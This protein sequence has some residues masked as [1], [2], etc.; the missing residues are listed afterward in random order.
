[1]RNLKLNA[2][3]KLSLIIAFIIGASY[4][5]FSQ[6]NFE[7]KSS[8]FLIL[9]ETTGDGVKLTSQEGCAWKELTFTLNPDQPQAI[10]QYGMTSLNKSKPTEDKNLASFLFIIKRTKEGISLSGKGGT[11]WTK[12]SFDCTKGK[13]SQYVDFNGMAQKH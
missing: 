3:L 11:A 2:F 10:D 7:T 4:A 12:L 8:K 13:C 6:V 9:V 1:M 5:V